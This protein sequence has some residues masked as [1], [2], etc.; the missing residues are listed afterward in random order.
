MA[1]S[2]GHVYV[3]DKGSNSVTDALVAGGKLVHVVTGGGLSGPDGEAVG[4]GYLWVANATGNTA[5]RI[6]MSTDAPQDFSSGSYGFGSP[7]AVAESGG[8]IYVLSPFGSS[9]MVTK[10]DEVTGTSP[11]YMCNTNAAFYF[12]N[13]SAITI[14][15]GEVWVASANGANYPDAQAANGSLTELAAS[16]GTLVQTVR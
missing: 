4:S 6:T 2:G 10:I 7:S 14:G 15:N 9:P 1:V 12:S 16:D 8:Y 11:W 5:S 3:A 13:L